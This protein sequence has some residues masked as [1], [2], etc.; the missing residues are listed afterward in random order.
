MKKVLKAMIGVLV[1]LRYESRTFSVDENKYLSEL[2]GIIDTSY[3][4][5]IN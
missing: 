4:E 1:S 2:M 5:H 3:P